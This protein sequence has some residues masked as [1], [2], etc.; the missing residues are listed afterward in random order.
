MSAKPDVLR[1]ATGVL[2]DHAKRQGQESA[3]RAEREAREARDARA[4]IVAQMQARMRARAVEQRRRSWAARFA[5][6]AGAILLALGAGKLA[7]RPSTPLAMRAPASLGIVATGRLLDGAATAWHDGRPSPVAAGVLASGD[8]V[9]TAAGAHA[10][11]ALSTGTSVVLAPSA[12]V[13]FTHVEHAQT[14]A[15]TSGGVNARVAKLHQGERFLVRTSDTEVEVRGTVFEVTVVP[16]DPSCGDGTSTRV[17]VSE[18]VVVVRNHG[19][20]TRVAAGERWPAGCVASAPAS[21]PPVTPVAPGA[22][23]GSASACPSASISNAPSAPSA[24]DSLAPTAPPSVA[25]PGPLA[26]RN[27]LFNEALAA[28]YRGDLTGALAGF[29]SYLGKFP[30]G[31]HAESAS[32]QRMRILAKLDRARAELAARAYLARN[33]QG[34]AREEAEAIVA[35]SAPKP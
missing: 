34:F 7:T 19:V 21:A 24:P 10:E 4:E 22:A 11:I 2:A 27:D 31:E 18:G 13:T 30:E 1:V 23:V 3:P 9:V 29:E 14:F 6:A 8:R 32:V 12:D 35:G 26:L 28:K 5:V 15:V 17:A 25:P 16:P 33:P 20:E